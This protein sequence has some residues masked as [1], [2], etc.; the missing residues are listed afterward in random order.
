M[1]DCMIRARS[2]AFV[3]LLA[4]A[5]ALAAADDYRWDVKAT[6]ER[7]Q[8]PGDVFGDVDTLTL[9]GTWFFA[10]VSTS[11]VPLAEAAFLGR[12]SSVSAIVARF[13]SQFEALDIHLNA[14]AASIGYYVP[15]TMI[16]AGAGVSHGQTIAA[17]NSV[18]V[19]KEY[20]TN[21]FG[22]LGVAPLRGLLITTDFHEDGYDPNVT[23]RYVG[24]LPNDH[25]YAGNV[26][27]VDPDG[28]DTSFGLGFDYY[29]DASFSAGVGYEDAASQWELRAEKF[30]SKSWALGISASTADDGDTF[31]LKVR[32]RH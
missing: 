5:P 24:K 2:W 15:N 14:Q 30:F 13:D 26:S 22:T 12:A 25:F 27:L 9:G 31:G 11:G 6:F 23:V 28:G 10:P 8:I 32:W 18:I 21:W 19:E 1:N 17:L 29:F 16:Y 20:V 4:I 3:T 7:D